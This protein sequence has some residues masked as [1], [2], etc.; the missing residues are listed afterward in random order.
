MVR[1]FSIVAWNACDFPQRYR[2]TTF[3]AVYDAVT[4]FFSEFH[5]ALPCKQTLS[6]ITLLS[7]KSFSSSTLCALW[8]TTDPCHQGRLC[9]E[10]TR[11]EVICF[12]SADLRLGMDH[13]SDPGA[14]DILDIVIAKNMAHS[15]EVTAVVE[16]VRVQFPSN[17]CLER[18]RTYPDCSV[19][20]V[21]WRP[22]HQLSR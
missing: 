6:Q 4:V 22:E 17:N 16:L 18:C 5:L 8:S 7:P 10:A 20:R 12:V 14:S 11:D 1:K 13:L 3:I 19:R 15:I 2:L 21:N 9:I